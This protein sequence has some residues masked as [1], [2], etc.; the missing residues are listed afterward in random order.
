MCAAIADGGHASDAARPRAS[1]GTRP[2][3]PGCQRWTKRLIGGWTTISSSS[4]SEKSR[5]AADRG[6]V[7]LD[8]LE[9]AVREVGAED[10]VD[11]VA[12][13]GSSNRARSSR[14]PR[15]GLRACRPSQI[16]S[17]SPSSRRSAPSAS[18]RRRRLRRGA[19]STPCRASPGGR[20]APVLPAQERRRRGPRL[21]S[22]PLDDPKPR[23]PR[24]RFGQ[25]VDLDELDRGEAAGRRAARSAS[26]ARRRTVRRGRCSGGHEQLAPVARVDEAG[27]VH[28]RDPVLRGEAGARLDE[29]RIARPGSR[30]RGPSRRARAH[31]GASSTRSHAERSRPASPA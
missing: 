3:R 13:A 20:A 6:V 15:S 2:G 14:R 7:R 11:D 31:P 24:S 1:R 28:D 30:R 26:R 12:F 16:P 8:V 10:D 9:R 29:A 21:P 18:R 17:S 5:E 27:R 22:V 4:S 19:A 25:L 23:T